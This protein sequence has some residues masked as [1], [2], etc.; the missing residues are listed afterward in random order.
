MAIGVKLWPRA[1]AVFSYNGRLVT[2]E[3]VG[4]VEA[5]FDSVALVPGR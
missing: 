5:L 2:S 1:A 3:R 4:E